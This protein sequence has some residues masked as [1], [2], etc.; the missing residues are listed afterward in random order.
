MIRIIV[1]SSR[2]LCGLSV[3]INVAD[4]SNTHMLRLLFFCF[5]PT[6]ESVSKLK[7]GFLSDLGLSVENTHVEVAMWLLR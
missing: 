7:K 1:Q 5:I 3:Y 4:A 2:Q 6:K